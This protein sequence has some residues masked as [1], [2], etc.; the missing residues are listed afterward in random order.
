MKWPGPKWTKY[1]LVAALLLLALCVGWWLRGPTKA[2]QPLVNFF[3]ALVPIPSTQRDWQALKVETSDAKI[4]GM[5]M[6]VVTVRNLRPLLEVEGDT[7][8]RQ[9]WVF[10]ERKSDTYATIVT[11]HK[12]NKALR[13]DWLHG[14]V[15][16]VER[17]PKNSIFFLGPEE[18][19]ANFRYSNDFTITAPS[20]GPGHHYLVI[21]TPAGTSKTKWEKNTILV[22]SYFFPGYRYGTVLEQPGNP[23]GPTIGMAIVDLEKLELAGY[24]PFPAQVGRYPP[25]TVLDPNTDTLLVFDLDIAWVV[26]V[27][28]RKGIDQSKKPWPPPWPH[29]ALGSWRGNQDVL[30]G[31]FAQLPSG[32]PVPPKP[33]DYP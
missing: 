16:E 13:L 29:P 3:E 9:I 33:A 27:D 15:S 19:P 23:M 18:T 5:D 32:A 4:S 20:C 11:S 6:P 2:Q 24:V 28:L 17:P 12:A 21:H 1:L 8:V 14:K 26:C 10:N 31:R 7:S 25:L 22:G 30:N